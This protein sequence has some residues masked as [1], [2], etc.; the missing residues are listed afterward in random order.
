MKGRIIFFGMLLLF[1]VSCNFCELFGTYDL[2]NNFILMQGDGSNEEIIIYCTTKKGCCHSGISVIPSNPSYTDTYIEEIGY[3]NNWIIAK[4]GNKI[5]KDYHA[6]W[7]IKKNF[8]INI[9]NCKDDCN[10]I[11]RNNV[12]GPFNNI[13]FTSK[14]NKLGIK[15]QLENIFK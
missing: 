1:F 14:K 9:D 2:G 8:K 3:D 4:S 10:K 5:K 13:E 15:L 12:F 11:I 6:Y 7:I